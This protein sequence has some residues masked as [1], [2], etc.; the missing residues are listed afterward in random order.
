MLCT[1]CCGTP[2][3]QPGALIVVRG[4]LNE[5]ALN[6]LEGV[7]LRPF[8]E[9]RERWPIRLICPSNRE[10]ALKE[11]NVR[12]AACYRRWFARRKRTRRTPPLVAT[13]AGSPSYGTIR[14]A[15]GVFGGALGGP[16][17]GTA[18]RL[19]LGLY[20][21]VEICGLQN[22]PDLN[23]A[24]AFVLG[25]DASRTTGRYIVGLLRAK[26]VLAVQPANLRRIA[27]G[28]GLGHAPGYSVGC[29]GVGGAGV[30]WGEGDGREG[31]GV[32]G[33]QGR[34]A[35]REYE[36][37]DVVRLQGLENRASLNGAI[38]IL[39][40]WKADTSRWATTVPSRGPPTLVIS[41]LPA[42]MTL[43]FR[44]SDDG[45][46]K[47]GESRAR[48]PGAGRTGGTARGGGG[49]GG[50]GIPQAVP[51]HGG[52]PTGGS[53]TGQRRG[54]WAGWGGGVRHVATAYAEVVA[55][56]GNDEDIPMAVPVS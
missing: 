45:E 3:V 35:P 40:E 43:V 17:S 14:V 5:P 4:L 39:G 22:K 8:D 23:G 16:A 1:L 29:G 12:P 48:S 54:Q 33:A 18:G 41:V 30:H 52:R 31:G 37:G 32:G 24:V 49:R 6:G 34:N 2:Q 9:A 20:D 28:E 46:S 38:G 53:P 26:R 55:N 21:V 51:V 56:D 11:A 15:P 44:S 47:G 25:E 27:L 7:V 10:V 42:N 50:R 13:A 19:R 36:E